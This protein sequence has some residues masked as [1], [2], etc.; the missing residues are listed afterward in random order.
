M[1][2]L[3]SLWSSAADDLAA[4]CCTSATRD[5]KTIACRAENEG[6]WFLAVVLADFGKVTQKWL[7]QGRVGSRHDLPLWKWGKSSPDHVGC[8]RFLGGFLELIF[9]PCSGLVLDEPNIEAI[10]A[11]RQLT[12]MFSKIALPAAPQQRGGSVKTVRSDLESKAMSGF[13]QC[14][15][16]VRATDR[17]L[18][19]HDIEAFCRMSDMLFGSVFAAVDREVYNHSL[20]PRHGPGA[21]ADRLT[22][23]GKYD[24]RIWPTRLER[25]LPF[26]EY[27]LP[28][29]SYYSE[30]DKVNFLEPGAEIPVRVIS[31]PKTL[32]SPRIIA[33]EPTAMQYMQQGI[34]RSLLNAL[35]KDSILRRVI[36]FDDQEPN[37]QMAMAGSLSRELA[38]LDLS[39]ASDRVSNQLVRAM[40]R[41][42]PHMLEAVDATRSRRADVPGHG[43]I[44]LSKFASM[45]SALCFPFEAMVFT[46]LIFMGISS[47]LTMSLSE[48]D[49]VRRFSRQ[50]RV[51]GDDLIVPS[52][53]VLSV[54]QRL[55]HFGAQVNLSKS[56]WS[57]RFRESRGREYYAGN[58]VS[59]VKVRQVLPTQRQDAS[60]VISAVALRN[61]FYQ[62]GLWG[63]CRYLDDY[64]GKLLKYFPNVTPESRL[65]GRECFL[66]YDNQRTHPYLHS[67]LAKGYYVK[68]ELPRDHLEGPGAL[69]K[70]FIMSEARNKA[71]TFPPERGRD[72]RHGWM[73][74]ADE[75]HLERSG[76]PKHVD[77]KLGWAS[78]F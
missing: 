69:L 38:T 32:K 21:T 61:Q 63:A 55:E 15:Q 74:P 77:I 43:V 73:P 58:D 65:L 36:G 28:S 47:E 2:S 64:L 33:I 13:V 70:C 60:L 22:S 52:R 76:R 8:P 10:Y 48:K 30:M 75:K 6:L 49:V 67:P 45:G 41:N 29:W 24:Q 26:G 23:N 25:I 44:R 9:D 4:R 57:G 62:A 37:R 5:S 42:H 72:A 11:V 14:E 66:G 12:L 3:M 78:P 18:R 20:H 1:K 50:V 46:T 40:L 53:H 19:P 54:V 34:L 51:F 71:E 7:D 35:Q 68:A 31:V 59:I 27:A 16:E 17:R 56:F 39:D